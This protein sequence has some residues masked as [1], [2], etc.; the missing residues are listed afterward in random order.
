[1]R[2]RSSGLSLSEISEREEE[3]SSL[4][5]SRLG[6]AAACELDGDVSLGATSAQYRH[7]GPESSEDEK[8][9]NRWGAD[10]ED[11]RTRIEDGNDGIGGGGGGGGGG[12]SPLFPD[13]VGKELND[14][15]YQV[16]GITI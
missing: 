10:F 3:E 12:R 6:E 15:I 13:V 5:N 2:S 4:S 1:M 11:R 8:A 14:K 16:I 7:V 9:K